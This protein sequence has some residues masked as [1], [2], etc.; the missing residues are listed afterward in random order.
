MDCNKWEIND[1]RATK[2]ANDSEL[3]NGRAEDRDY[4]PH[5]VH[6]GEIEHCLGLIDEVAI[7]LREI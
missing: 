6:L 7:A 2:E 1:R 4:L 5:A 3:C